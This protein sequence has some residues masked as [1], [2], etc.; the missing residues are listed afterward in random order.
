MGI[1][2]SGYPYIRESFY[3]TFLFYPEEVYFLLPQIWK[4]KGGKAVYYPPKGKNVF[5]TSA[6]FHHSNYPI[7]GGILKGWMPLFPIHLFKLRN[8]INLVYSPSEPILLTTLYQGFW[9]KVF[10]LKHVIFSWENIAYE[11]KLKGLKG[12]IQKIILRLN[13]LFSDGIICG[14]KKSAEI[15][16]KFTKKP[17]AVI[18]LSGLDADFFTRKEGE[19]HRA[20]YN[21]E[22]KII[23]TF[24]GSISYR[25]G[26][27][28]ILKVFKY[29]LAELSNARLIIVGTGEY[30]Q[31]IEKLI[32]D[33]DLQKY[34]TRFPWLSHNELR[35]ILNLSDIFLY[36]SLSHGGW[37]EQFG[38]SMAEGSLME[39]PVISSLSGSIEDIV[40]NGKT[41]LL[42][43]PNDED[44][45]KEA[46]IRLSLDSELRRKMGQAGRQYIIKNFS[47][48]I[49]AEKFYEFFKEINLHS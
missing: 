17:L 43:K 8:K 29:I 12:L 38:Y 42:V 37:E 48:Q 26:I 7:I 2:I 28:L 27:H 49:V 10:G 35:G 41:G 19:N 46:M 3:K 47:Y 5:K 14:N 22:N 31:E 30:E 45:L 34:I 36:P 32:K 44:S 11:L 40:V 16:K 4:I 25:K 9:A 39:L 13:I 23:F 21:L 15:F 24:I 1:L 6:F 33:L 20:K 18:P